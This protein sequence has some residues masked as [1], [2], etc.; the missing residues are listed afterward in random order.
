VGE[1]GRARDAKSTSCG[2]AGLTHLVASAAEL[3]EGRQGA[4]EER[5][6]AVV[7]TTPVLRRSSNA[8]PRSSSSHLS[9]RLSVAFEVPSARAAAESEPASTTAASRAIA[10]NVGSSA[11]ARFYHETPR[12]VPGP[13]RPRAQ[14]PSSRRRE[15]TLAQEVPMRVLEV[16]VRFLVLLSVVAAGG[17]SDGSDDPALDAV[18]ES[19]RGTWRTGC[20]PMPMEDGSTAYATFEVINRGERGSFQFS[21]F[22][23]EACST[24]LADFLL[25]SRQVIGAL[26]PEAGPDAR[27]LDIFYERQSVTPHVADF[28]ALFEGAGCGTGPYAIGQTI[29]TSATGCL[30]FPPIDACNADYDLIRIDGDRFYNGVRGGD[31]CAPEGRPS[32]LN[33]FWFERV[34]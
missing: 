19:F 33:A 11:M 10:S 5:C 14:T 1:L 9:A 8:T 20:A 25:E 23:D 2:E 24:R 30:D 15:P 12:F 31:M 29:D 4:V 6:P 28:V 13:P 26:V 7:G 34:E 17:C 16:P 21:L 32:A 18:R 3:V 27:E 22:A